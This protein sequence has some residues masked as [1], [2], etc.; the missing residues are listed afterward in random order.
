MCGAEAGQ[1]GPAQRP[2]EGGLV[3]VSITSSSYGVTNLLQVAASGTRGTTST[4]VAGLLQNS[5][6]TTTSSSSMFDALSGSGSMSAQSNIFDVLN[7]GGAG[8]SISSILQQQKVTTQ[9]NQIYTTVA[10]RLAALQAGSL[11]PS[12]NWEKVAAYSMQTGQPMTVALDSKGQV[13]V[14]PQAQA[15][16]SKFNAGQQKILTD[17]MKAVATMAGKITANKT[18]QGMIDKLAGAE[19]DLNGV[20]VGALSPQASTPN[21]WEQLGVQ[22]MQLNKPFTISLDS[23][24]NLQVQ[25]QAMTPD[26]SLPADQQTILQKAAQTL[27]NVLSPSGLITTQWQSD[28]AA[29]AKN[30]VPFH[31]EIDTSNLDYGPK[32]D[33]Y[34]WP[35]DAAGKRTSVTGQPAVHKNGVPG[36]KAVEN[37][38]DNIT[39]AFLNDTPYPD[40][41]AN[42]PALKQAAALIKAGKPFFLDFDK[43]GHV[44]AKEATAQ[45][46]I[47]YNAPAGSTASLGTGSVL[48]VTA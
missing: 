15:D 32:T 6:A 9:K 34:G 29:F 36:V 10:Q 37:S 41:G 11:Q 8:S 18:N 17:T 4:G 39:P 1:N 44:T 24:G 43:G 35:V 21:N 42:S 40:I 38:A 2:T 19:N 48:S 3:M 23:Q 45:N 7:P 16:L 13:Q 26:P 33:A 47:Q 46:I 28:A 14:T 31:L 5:Q 12:A 22:L 25:D 27:P 20:F 30:G